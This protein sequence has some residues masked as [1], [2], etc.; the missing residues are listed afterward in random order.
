MFLLPDAKGM[1]T[2]HTGA[3]NP[4][5]GAAGLARYPPKVGMVGREKTSDLFR[6]WF[7]MRSACASR[8]GS[9]HAAG[10]T[11]KGWRHV[12]GLRR[13]GLG[14]RGIDIES[15]FVVAGGG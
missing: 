6:L 10:V 1:D 15:F 11:W 13:W 8:L 14:E 4:V 3:G 12:P 2:N 5:S 9:E 7:L